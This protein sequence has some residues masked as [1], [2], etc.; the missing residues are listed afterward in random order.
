MPNKTFFS[1]DGEILYRS[2]QDTYQQ[3]KKTQLF[4][5]HWHMELRNKKFSSADS[6]LCTDHHKTHANKGKKTH[7]AS[8]YRYDAIISQPLAQFGPGDCIWIQESKPR[9]K[10]L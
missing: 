6:D 7:V 5:N 3:R 9:I 1:T 2:S 10:M 4:V 8:Q